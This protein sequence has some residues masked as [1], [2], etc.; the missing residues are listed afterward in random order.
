MT[1]IRKHL[2]GEF[3]WAD[4]GAPDV[5]GAKK[6]YRSVLGLEAQD[7][8]MGP[9][10]CYSL[11][12]IKGKDVCALYPMMPE[13]RG[14]PPAWVPYIAVT[15]VDRTLK[16]V[17]AAGGKV[18]VGPVEAMKAGR[19]AVVQDPQGAV[20]ALWQ[21]RAHKGS[22]VKGVP[23]SICWRDLSTSDRPAAAKFYG[24]VFGWKL[25]T[26]DFSGNSYYLFKQG[27]KGVGG[28]WPHP[29]PKHL[30]AWFTYWVVESCAKAVTKAKRLGGKVILGPITVPKTCTFA[31]VRDDQ[32][33][34]FGV[35][36]PIG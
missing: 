35:L 19:M 15:S 2:P 32:G 17:T 28:M 29:L 14:R 8:P 21:A 27:K 18:C 16:K 9:G 13:Q 31:I 20:F 3:C 11:L 7:I 34:A 24:K 22:K 33:A 12:Q 23:G 1:A 10:Q 4:L 5:A 6:F 25:E 36:E 26:Q 30:P